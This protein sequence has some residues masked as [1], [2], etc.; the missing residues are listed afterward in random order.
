MLKTESLTNISAGQCLL[1][2]SHKRI[3]SLIFT[4]FFLLHCPSWVKRILLMVLSWS[5]IKGRKR[6]KPKQTTNPYKTNSQTKHSALL[7]CCLLIDLMCNPNGCCWFFFSLMCSFFIMDA[8]IRLRCAASWASKMPPSCQVHI[9]SL[10]LQ[11]NQI[12]T[13]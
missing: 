11:R 8:I 12:K 1:D 13:Y 5:N 7:G 9:C 3:P 4:K 6:K 2:G 10:P